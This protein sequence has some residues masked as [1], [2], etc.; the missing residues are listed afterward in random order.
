LRIPLGTKESF[1]VNLK[2]NP[3]KVTSGLFAEHKVKKGETLSD[4]SQKY[5]VPL[6]TIMEANALTKKHVLKI[7]ERILIPSDNSP[8][9]LK[10]QNS[11]K[12]K[13][14]ESK[15]VTFYTVK[16]GENLSQIAQKFGTTSEQVKKLNGLEN[17]NFV[18]K[19]QSL[20]IPATNAKKGVVFTEHQVKKGETLSYLAAQY[21][22]SISAIMEANHLTDMHEIK[23]GQYLLIPTRFTLAQSD[24]QGA[25]K[26][27]L[28]TVK[29]SDTAS[30]LTLKLE[31]SS[32]RIENI[33]GLQDLDHAKDGQ[34]LQIPIARE[35]IDSRISE[36]KWIVYIVK[37]GDTL[38]DIARKF[39]VLVESLISWNRVRFPSQIQVGDRI[40]IL[41]TY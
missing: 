27:G 4:I 38:W 31:T 11:P 35:E 6:S 24:T 7:G 2:E 26:I 29:R 15:K 33:N 25:E 23:T 40:K 28:S 20:K 3:S 8:Q 39:G 10:A 41:Q 32:Q 13:P 9:N 36:G 1:S 19:G 30:G 12:A 16:E 22:V 34:K 17:Q 18:K 21:G 5:G 37:Q 14:T